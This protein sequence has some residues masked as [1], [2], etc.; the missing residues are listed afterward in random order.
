MV[1]NLPDVKPKI[2]LLGVSSTDIPL[3][4]AST[5]S[6][7]TVGEGQENLVS[8][9][10]GL[11]L[12]KKALSGCARR[13]LKN[14]KARASEAGTG[15]IQQPGYASAQAGRNLKQNPLETKVRGQY[16]YRYGQSSKKA[17]G[18]IRRL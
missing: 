17:R 8:R 7:P 1:R 18:T 13:K 11:R 3:Q 15:G 9:V 6:K 5:S 10:G 2:H 16:P 14:A 4:T 12:E